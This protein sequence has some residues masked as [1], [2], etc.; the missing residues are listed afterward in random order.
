MNILDD[1]R[2]ISAVN[3]DEQN[4]ITIGMKC[5]SQVIT[6]IK[7]YGQGAL[8]CDVPWIAIYS[9]ESIIKR[10]N[11]LLVQS[12]DYKPEQK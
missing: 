1:T 10:V 3:F 2:E 4:Y 6:G 5:G 11:T 12:V 8:H 9:G 7:I